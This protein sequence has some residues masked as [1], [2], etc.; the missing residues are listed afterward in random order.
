MELLKSWLMEQLLLLKRQIKML[1]LGRSKVFVK[2]ICA[3]HDPAVI[4]N[5]NPNCY[6]LYEQAFMLN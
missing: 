1:T 6:R 5:T 4:Y 3:S 2:E